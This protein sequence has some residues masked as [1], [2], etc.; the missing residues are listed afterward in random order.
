MKPTFFAS[1]ADLRKWLKKNHTTADELW[2][3]MYKKH[4]GKPSITWPQVVDE[5]LCFGWIDGIRKGIDADSYMN[6]ITPRRK[7]SN[8]SAINLK[9]VE[10]LKAL[11][12]MQ[13]AGLKAHAERN[14]SRTQQYSSEQREVVFPAELL[15]QFKKHKP[16]WAFF[17]A[18]PP[19]YRKTITWWVISAK[20]EDTRQKRLARLIELSASQQRMDLMSPFGKT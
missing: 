6:R 16:A 19:S 3:G 13:P 9:R 18:Q 8:W 15:S 11:G 12:L 4:T 20:R 1:Q 17:S 2:V 10:E 7:N 5:V 14:H